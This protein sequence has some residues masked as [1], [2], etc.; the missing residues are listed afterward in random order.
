[1]RK[2]FT[3]FFNAFA[4][5]FSALEKGAQTIDNYASWAEG[6]SRVFKEESE[7]ERTARLTAL[8]HKLDQQTKALTAQ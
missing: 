8:Q 4:V 3:N 5:L 7:L 1:M 6:E 2:M